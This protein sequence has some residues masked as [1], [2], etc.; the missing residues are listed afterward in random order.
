MYFKQRS[1]V[2][3]DSFLVFAIH[4]SG[5]SNWTEKASVKSEA[6]QFWHKCRMQIQ[7]F[8]I[9]SFSIYRP[10]IQFINSV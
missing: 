7:H 6:P 9:K 10:I 3:E 4:N 5:N 1:Q 8:S 2:Y